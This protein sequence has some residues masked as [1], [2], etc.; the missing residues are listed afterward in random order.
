MLTYSFSS[1]ELLLPS[2]KL[3]FCCSD[4]VPSY[5]DIVRIQ[6]NFSV[7]V[8]LKYHASPLLL[9]SGSLYSI[10]ILKEPNRMQSILSLD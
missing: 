10:Y 1:R 8:R 9:E 4:C 7:H 5:E 3:E 2:E 6:N